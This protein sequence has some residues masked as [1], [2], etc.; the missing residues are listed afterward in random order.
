MISGMRREFSRRQFLVGG[1]I[2]VAAAYV[3]PMRL[4]GNADD[5]VEGAI[6]QSATAKIE[7][8]TLRRNVSVLLGPGGNIA[9][10]AGSDGKILVDAEIVSARRQVSAALASISKD[11]I[12][13]LINTHW[14]FD[15]TGGNEWLH[16][17]GASIL[18]QENTRKH[19]LRD[20][21]VDGWNHT[22]LKAPAG[23]IPSE[24]F[25]EKHTLHVNSSTMELRHYLPAHTDSDISVHF[26]EADIFHA[27]DTFWNRSYPFIDYSTGGS[28]DG[29][30]RAAEEN[31]SKVS[32]DTIIVPGHGAVS[33]RSDL[34]LFRD[35]L[36]EM[37]EKVAVFKRQGRTLSEVI[38]AK[39]GA[40]YDE[41]WGQS[42]MSPSAFVALVYQG[43]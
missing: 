38:D 3:A 16:E 25:Q 4:F 9:V 6:K 7:V 22:F 8:Q 23:A 36:V 40:R 11:P 13:Q 2:A 20:T 15:H 31:L 39:P 19:L 17:A 42:F 5:L 30:I 41:E 18:A 33:G 35:V 1:A 34:A 27:G 24:V 14:H 26:T 28:I 10:L 43:V 21:R 32:R 37:R 12:R 29:Q